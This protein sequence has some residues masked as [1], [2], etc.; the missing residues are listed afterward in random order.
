MAPGSQIFTTFQTG[1]E[2]TSGTAV[3]ATRQWY[4]DGTGVIDI[5][6]MLAM[7]GGN[8]GVYNPI[9]Y[10]TS[11]GIAVALNYRSLPEM[12]VAWDE[13]PFFFNQAGGGTA[14]SGSSA[15]KSWTWAAGGTAAMTPK[16]YTIEAGD[17]TQGYQF[18][19]GMMREFTLSAAADGLTQVEANWFARQSTKASKTAL[20]PN[21][22]LRIPGLLWKPRFATAQSGLSGASDQANFLVNWSWKVTTGLVP[23]FYQDGLTYFGQHAQTAISGEIN[24]TVESTSTAVS[25]FYDKWNPGGTPTLDF[26]QLKATG[27][28][29]GSSNYSA[30]L[31]AAVNYT[32]VEPIGAES[33]GINLYNVTAQTVYDSTWGQSMGGTI[34]CS[35]AA[36][37]A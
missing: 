17:E 1:R 5:D 12:G 33:D 28:T 16:S 19:Y 24:L 7:H 22:A 21:A 20:T 25:Q 37:T 36:L 14:G 2:A 35:I 31:Q 11:Q 32:K 15:D 30:T 9:S 23:R 3:A 34:V 18:E 26:I 13:L 29:L 10:A 4:P 8:R 6:S 27:P